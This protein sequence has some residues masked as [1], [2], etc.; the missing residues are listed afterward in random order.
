MKPRR[1]L[2]R[3]SGGLLALVT[4]L[5]C[6]DSLFLATTSDIGEKVVLAV[7]IHLALGAAMLLVLPV[8]VASHVLVHRQH[9]NRRA[10][11][12][13]FVVA[14]FAAVGALAGAVLWWLGKSS[15]LWGVTLLHEI[16]FVSALGAYLAHR[17]RARVTPALGGEK[18]GAVTALGLAMLVGLLRLGSLPGPSQA[19]AE[20]V[21][22]LSQARTVDGHVL[23]AEMLT[24]SDY[25][26]TCHGEIAERWKSSVHRVSSLNDPFYAATLGLAQQHRTP[27]DLVFCGGCHDVALVFSG[28]M[29]EAHP[30]PGEPLTDVG[31]PCLGCHA[32]VETPGVLGN[33][34]Y[35]LADPEH[36]PY[37]G[38]EDE[39]EVE[40]NARLI[41]S[42]PGKHLASFGPPHLRTAEACVGCHKAHIP[43]ELNEH[44]WVAGPND[45]DAW[46]DSR[47]GANSARTF[48]E[49]TGPKRCA[50]CHMP[51]IPSDDPAARDGLVA[52]HAFPGANTALP[53]VRQ[54]QD[55]LAR[56]EAFLQDVVKVDVGAVRV[57]GPRPRTILAPG[58]EVAVAP[59]APL[60]IDVV[61]TNT[62]S[63][64]MFPGGIADMREV[65]LELTLE[66]A[67]GVQLVSG[68]LDEEG[69]LDPSAHRWESV[70]VNRDGEV[71][72]RHEVEQLYVVL[73]ERRIALGASDV[74]QITLDAP[75]KP[76][77]LT[78]RILHRKFR[79][80]Y[81][82]FALGEDA[83]RMPVTEMAR[84]S[85]RFGT[86]ESI[87][88]EPGERLRNLGIAHLLRGNTVEAREASAAAA[89]QLPD[90]HGP[91]HDLARAALADGD[92]DRAE[93]HVRDADA[94]SPGHP[95]GAW[96][97]GT[98]RFGQGRHMEAIAAFDRALERY[99]RD[100]EV[101]AAK[102]RALFKLEKEEEAAAVLEEVLRIDP[103]HLGA[104]AILTR[105]RA[106][107]GDMEATK[108]HEAAWER[109]RSYSNDRAVTE[110]ARQSDPDIDRRANQQYILPLEPPAVGWEPALP[111]HAL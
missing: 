25:C 76:S 99:P 60:T 49:P 111:A 88:K 92:L 63:G 48:Y 86:Q 108:R 97:L 103:E 26:A 10:R 40:E 3:V 38:S 4:L 39:S 44:R 109:H 33:A 68:W 69:H 9:S 80:E 95:T 62:G 98:I 20:L 50:G 73:Y 32:V 29:A 96:L 24:D 18:L 67:D 46:F 41:R 87:D 70:L 104:H 78:A 82:Q 21:T 100:R 22:G 14:T 102:G 107:Q 55:W 52:D 77:T 12:V 83:R 56:S 89:P 19:R 61:V 42:K 81:V 43:P 66:D 45:Y 1:T 15:A 65:W 13:G 16:A 51:E 30:R 35:V 106:E 105:I 6:A 2:Q 17:L 8:F 84:T 7:R 37:Y 57:G 23:D 11:N 75:S 93:E 101:L 5:L 94:I 64:H 31:I 54:D 59:G 36:Y 27:E 58:Q 74:A 110:A 79:R 72:E 90:A 28:R 47:A 34:S 85:L 91:H 71:L 53:V